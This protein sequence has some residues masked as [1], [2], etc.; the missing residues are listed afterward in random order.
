MA[1]EKTLLADR[2]RGLGR[3][4]RQSAKFGAGQRING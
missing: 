4:L 1:S 3:R 2:A